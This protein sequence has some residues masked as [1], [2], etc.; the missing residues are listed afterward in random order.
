[1]TILIGFE[2]RARVTVTGSPAAFP[3]GC[4]L[5]GQARVTDAMGKVFSTL[6]TANTQIVR[7]SDTVI[8][9]V[10][11]PEDTADLQEGTA[12]IDVVRTDVTPPA[13]FGFILTP[14][15]KRPPT[16]PGELA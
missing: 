15:V 3:A 7:V 13:H 2:W 4:Q 10:I 9:L 11:P 16:R 12:V 8:D 6:T 14:K 1:M 5:A